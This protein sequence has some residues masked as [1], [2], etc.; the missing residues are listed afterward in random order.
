MQLKKPRKSG[1][2]IRQIG[3]PL[4][5]ATAAL[6]GTGVNTEISAQELGEWEI[7]TAMLYYGE[8]DGRV[9]D[10]SLN[11]LARKQVREDSFLNLTLAIDTLTGASPN[12]AVPIDGVQTFTRPSG[13]DQYTIGAGQQPLDDSF[14]DTRVALSANWEQPVGR[15]SLINVGAS[16][17]DEY[18]YTHAGFNAKIARD[19]NNRNTTLSAGV[20]VASDSINPVGGTP[21]G[22]TAMLGEEDLSNRIGDQSKDVTDILVGVTQVLN[23]QTLLQVNYSLSQ[24]DGYMSDPYKLLSVVDSVSG[25]PVA[26]PDPEMYLYRFERRPEQ[27]DKESLFALLKRDI[28]GNVLDVSYRYMTDDWGIDSQTIDLRYRLNFG[29]D[30]Y[31]EPHIRFYSQNEAD[32]YHRVLIDGQPLPQ[33]ASADYRLGSFSAITVGL[34]YGRETDR[35]EISTRVELYT[36]SGDTDPA[37]NFGILSGQDLYPDL[38]AIIAQFSYRFG[39]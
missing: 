6:L 39:R 35:G 13:N 34:K 28:G 4:A 2:R 38:N 21:T 18:D 17:S 3:R 33:F 24:S 27:R 20:A 31:L 22:L 11:A 30:K 14:Q 15:L 8:S 26:G 9:K 25:L 1:E 32:F 36:Q 19:F 16:F 29:S 23:R 37:A 7:D 10:L 12:G 5:A